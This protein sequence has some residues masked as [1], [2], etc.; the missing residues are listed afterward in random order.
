MNLGYNELKALS[1][2]ISTVMT[3]HSCN[4][5]SNSK[6]VFDT[7]ILTVVPMCTKLHIIVIFHDAKA[8]F[9]V[10]D[11]VLDPWYEALQPGV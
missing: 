9:S 3:K 8:E 5:T 1:G 7:Y 6:F 2:K 11:S 4:C 10:T